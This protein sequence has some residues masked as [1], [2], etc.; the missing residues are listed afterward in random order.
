[1]T[2]KNNDLKDEL[3]A[4]EQ[5]MC[6]RWVAV[7]RELWGVRDTEEEAAFCPEVSMHTETICSSQAGEVQIIHA[8]PPKATNNLFIYA[9]GG[10]WISPLNKDHVKWAKLFAKLSRYQVFI[11][12]YKL[13][14]EF[15]F[16]AA[17]Y[18][19]VTVYKHA[20][21]N[22]FD[23]I[24]V[25]G[26]SSGG[27]LSVATVLYAL[28]HQLKLPDKV[29]DIC[30]FHDFYFEQYQSAQ[31]IGLEKNSSIDMR[32]VGFNRA[33]YV[34]YLKDWK[35]P[36]ASPLYANLHE[37]PD[38]FVFVAA[39]DPL[40]DDNIA[41]ANK[42]KKQS[43]SNVL[44]KIYPDMPHSFHCHMNLAPIEAQQATEDLVDFLWS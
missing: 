2:Q 38:T 3:G 32:L 40:C 26:D 41:F 23:K 30:S 33:C 44:L 29:L 13:C 21:D 10:G 8:V 42:L 27:N 16:P 35:N 7:I 31:T 22:S 6:E 12:E 5:T 34:P 24:A 14:P 15:P 18:D 43:N 9:H 20:L 37:F 11:V 1:M 36:Y 19:M 39:Q 25:G 17:L 28:D 4:I